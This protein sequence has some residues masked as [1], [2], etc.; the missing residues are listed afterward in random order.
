MEQI[1]GSI[2]LTPKDI[3][4]IVGCAINAARKEHASIRDALGKARITVKDYCEYWK[5]S[6]EEVVACLNKNR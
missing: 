4:L 1:K 2:Y 5:T 3:Q 6:V